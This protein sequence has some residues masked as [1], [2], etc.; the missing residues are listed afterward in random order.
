MAAETFPVGI[1]V[2]TV[3]L[4][5]FVNMHSPKVMMTDEWSEYKSRLNSTEVQFV[6]N[7]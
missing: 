3:R 7:P 4:L 2:V 1:C 6:Y 5:A